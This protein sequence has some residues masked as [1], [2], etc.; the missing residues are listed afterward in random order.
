M[1]G[2]RPAMTPT[3]ERCLLSFPITANISALA[4]AV[5]HE[6]DESRPNGLRTLTSA[7]RLCLPAHRRSPVER[8]TIQLG[9]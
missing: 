1:S 2:G 6:S 3:N 4:L 7:L 9:Q 8:A 5:I